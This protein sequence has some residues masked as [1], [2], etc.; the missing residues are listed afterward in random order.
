MLRPGLVLISPLVLLQLGFTA[1]D[2]H[3]RECAGDPA[4]FWWVWTIIGALIV[5]A[6]GHFGIRTGADGHD[7]RLFEIAVFVVLAVFLIVHAGGHNT[8]Y[9]FGTGHPPPTTT[10]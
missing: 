2:T 6:A 4:N 9:V 7:P 1:A 8:V 3:H 10:A 5:M